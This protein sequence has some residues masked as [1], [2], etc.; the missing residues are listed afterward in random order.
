MKALASFILRGQSQAILVTVGFAVLSLA[1]PLFG[2]LSGAAVALVTLRHGMQAGVVLMA[3]ATL[4]VGLLAA[5]SLGNPAPA[6][7]FLAA[8]WLP[9]WMLGSLLRASRSLPLTLMLAGGLGLLGVLVVYLLLDDVAGWWHGILLQI[10]N[11]VMDEAGL[12]DRDAIL[13]A[14][15]SV[16]RVMTGM[17]AAGMVLNAIICLFLARGLQALLFNPGGFREEF[18]QLRMGRSLSG[19]TLLLALLYVLQMGAISSMAADMLIV[20]LSLYMVQGL[21]L[22]HAVVAMKQLHIAWLIG[23]YV[24][25]FVVLPQLVLAV[26]AVGLLDTWVDLRQRIAGPGA[27]EE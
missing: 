6:L 14:L 24:V 3:G 15:E 10:F 19:I 20:L 7:M 2:V 1:L 11:P 17:M 9:L 4:V 18:Q 22:A 21:A 23:L 8:L 27:G 26:A 5:F 13:A 12:A 16:S 25:A